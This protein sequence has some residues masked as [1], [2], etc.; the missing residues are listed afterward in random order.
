LAYAGSTGLYWT[1]FYYKPTASASYYGTGCGFASVSAGKPYAGHEF[2]PVRLHAFGSG[3]AWLYMSSAPFQSP[4]WTTG[5]YWNIS[6]S[7][8]QYVGS[9]TYNNTAE[10][11]MA[12]SDDPL[13]LGNLYLQWLYF[14][15]QSTTYYTSQG[16]EAKVR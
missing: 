13:F 5:C 12:L 4:F 6:T 14:P 8:L 1:E 15:S 3:S 11:Q 9:T 7:T 10:V 2:F 16:I